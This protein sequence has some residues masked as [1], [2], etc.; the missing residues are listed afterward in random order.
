MNSNYELVPCF[1]GPLNG[2]HIRIR[3][4]ATYFQILKE[5]PLDTR[6]II[7]IEDTYNSLSSSFDYI[8]YVRDTM[9]FGY[10]GNTSRQEYFRLEEWTPLQ[11]FNELWNLNKNNGKN[12][13][14]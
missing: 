1:G 3:T 11:V 8:I 12:I 4:Y 14:N 13:R 9:G 6:S 5:T 10:N 7:D 2:K